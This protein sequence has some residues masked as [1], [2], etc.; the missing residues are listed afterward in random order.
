M[1]WHEGEPPKSVN[2]V[3]VFSTRG[4]FWM[5]LQRRMGGGWWCVLDL[6]DPWRPDWR[7][8]NLP[9]PPAIP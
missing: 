4:G 8:T 7:W 9:N 5:V 1:E 2:E 6:L 3:L